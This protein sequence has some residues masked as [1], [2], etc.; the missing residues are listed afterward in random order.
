M[1]PGGLLALW[2]NILTGRL[3][4]RFGRRLVVFL[5]M[6]VCGIAYAAFFSGIQGWIVPALW[7][8]AF[9]G[10]F[11]ADSLIKGFSAEIMPTAY[12]ATI[13]GFAY[14]AEI[15]SGGVALGLE[16]KWYDYFHAHGPAISV[17]LLAIPI[18]LVGILFLP[19]PAGRALE[20]ISHA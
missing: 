9:F 15:M 11:S 20:D 13:G 12:R 1:I 5:M 7:I 14:A 3:S 2:L 6:S 10:F 18:A 16:G 8:A 4:D 17:S 19:E